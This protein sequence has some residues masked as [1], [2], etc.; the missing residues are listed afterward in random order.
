MSRDTTITI[1]IVEDSRVQAFYLKRMLTEAGYRVL[2]AADGQEGLSLAST[3]GLALILSDINMPKMNGYAMCLKIKTTPELMNIPVVL[4]SE[5]SSMDDIFQG[6]ESKADGYILK[7]YDREEILAKIVEILQFPPPIVAAQK[8]VMVSVSE[9]PR[10]LHCTREQI[11][12]FLVSIYGRMLQKNQ[13]L[14]E[15]H[16]QLRL[17]NEKLM[18]SEKDL[19][20]N[21]WSLVQTVPDIIYQLDDEGRFVFV[22]NAIEKLGY[23][24][25]TLIGK[26]FS[27]IIDDDQI[28]EISRDHF[29]QQI[30]RD[31]NIPET[32]PKLFDERRSGQRKTTDLEVRIK[33]RLKSERGVERT[34]LM[35]MSSMRIL[36]CEV[37]SAGL[38]DPEERTRGHGQVGTVGVIRDM[39]ARKAAEEALE[40]INWQLKESEQ[41]AAEASRAKSEFLANM[42]HEIRTP[43]NAIVGFTDLARQQRDLSPKMVDYLYKIK[44]SSLSLLRLINDILDFSKIEA[45]K[46]DME[47]GEFQIH[48]VFHQLATLLR[49]SALEKG[50]DLQFWIAP[51]VP[52]RLQGDALRLGQVLTNLISNAIKFTHTGGVNITV[53][54]KK[55]TVAEDKVELDFYVQ[56]TGIGLTKDQ[57]SRLFKPFTQADSSVT[58][59]YGGTGLG[60]TI[61][62]RLVEMMGG[63]ISVS[64]DLNQGSCFTF[65]ARFTLKNQDEKASQA[66][67][68]PLCHDKNIMVVDDSPE[69]LDL[70]QSILVDFPCTVTVADSG[71]KA[72]ALI[73]DDLSYDL[74]ILDWKMPLMDGIEVV[75]KMK[76]RYA[77]EDVLPPKILML[78]AFGHEEVRLQAREVGVEAFMTKPV[79]IALFF[80]TLSHLFDAN[81]QHAVPLVEVKKAAIP[82]LDHAFD[83]TQ[84]LLAEDNEINQQVAKEMLHRLGCSVTV[85]DNGLE[86][87]EKLKTHGIQ[88]S[89]VLMDIQM[90]KMDGFSATRTI[91][92]SL[93][94]LKDLPI[95]AITAH[96]MR[97]DR[98]KCLKAG[99]QDYLTKPIDTE[100]L[101]HCLSQWVEPKPPAEIATEAP[102][103]DERTVAFFSDIK[104]LNSPV[105]LERLNGDV[106]LYQTLLKSFYLDYKEVKVVL[107]EQLQQKKWL[108]AAKIVHTIKGVAG[109]LAADQLFEEAK[110]LDRCLRAEKVSLDQSLLNNFYHALEALFQAIGSLE[111]LESSSVTESR[112]PASAPDQAQLKSLIQELLDLVGAF[113]LTAVNLFPRLQERL[114]DAPC[115]FE[116]AQIDKSVKA[117]DFKKAYHQLLQLAETLKI[118]LDD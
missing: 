94:L 1:L 17:S 60:L 45:G 22:N 113:N 102:S 15:A 72:L 53:E 55:V 115:Q 9:K 5:L 23:D 82:H 37:N 20:Q 111:S 98:E 50:L 14:E 85:V 71:G 41:R 80:E 89:A 34:S 75:Q 35:Q 27:T 26:H 4:L 57:I 67:L 32:P 42:S 91:R 30:K 28:T 112:K 92:K 117:L 114:Q 31:G 95:I 39:S 19:K 63:D 52:S 69:A 84:I 59:N 101:Y 68:Y 54:R 51:D 116:I 104:V 78:T 105:A 7:P 118:D 110:R 64:S 21:Y 70:I 36:P 109:N 61:C 46:L 99:M 106:T 66:S 93:P 44:T 90:P 16:L 24:C 77:K 3:P 79:N 108:A 25:D 38:S 62:K 81:Y 73:E 86:A 33:Y 40:K 13:Q 100:K 10:Q 103:A 74:V 12:H 48:D 11:A 49:Q 29:L 107:N 87:V 88:F 58:R 96:A 8:P 76:A 97:E 2:M 43:M 6:L 83:G 56:D 47:M 65:S 18:H